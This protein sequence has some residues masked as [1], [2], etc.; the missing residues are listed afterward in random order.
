MMEELSPGMPPDD[1]P[2][3]VPPTDADIEHLRALMLKEIALLQERRR[4][5]PV[6]T[7]V[8]T[9]QRGPADTDGEPKDAPRPDGVALDAVS[10]QYV[11]LDQMAAAVSRSK[12]TLEKRKRRKRNP[13]PPP[14]IEG[15]GGKPDEWRWET[16]RPWL[17]EEFG[18]PLPERFPTERFRDNRADRS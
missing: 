7:L 10:C 12:R 13:L 9:D 4:A 18:R 8:V 17:A 14:E 15:G 6:P 5:A 2:S 11:T 3:E 1:P 16:V